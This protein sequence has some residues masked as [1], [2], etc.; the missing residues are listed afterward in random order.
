MIW[1]I[2]EGV[3][4]RAS[5]EIKNALCPLCN[6]K[7]ISKCGK[8]KIWHWGHLK[9]SNCDNFKENETKWHIDWKN[10]FLKKNQEVIVEKFG[11]KHI[12]D[13]KTDEGVVIEFQNSSI[14]TKELIA[15]E[16]FWENLI[17]VING[18]TIGKNI[19][20]YKQHFKWKWPHET[21]FFSKKKIYVDC[22]K[23]KIIYQI[24]LKDYTFKKFSRDAFI[25]NHGGNPFK[26]EKESE[27]KI[28]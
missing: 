25:I 11:K 22:G 1:A 6:Q 21:W 15:R 5:P 12:A 2:K 8:I 14:S 9:K 7:V 20:F 26:N 4:I 10:N 18:D 17:W 19:Y 3:K 27:N 16:N 24:N 23:S 28:C 13:I